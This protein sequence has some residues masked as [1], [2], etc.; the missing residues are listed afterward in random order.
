ME[1]VEAVMEV[2]EELM[3]VAGVSMAATSE[4]IVEVA[5]DSVVF[6]IHNNLKTVTMVGDMDKVGTV[7]IC[8]IKDKIKTVNM[9]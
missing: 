5:V 9:A 2:A 4:E 3:E 8:M 7:T 6:L 1:P